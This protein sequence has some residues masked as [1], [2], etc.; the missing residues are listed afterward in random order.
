[1][2]LDPKGA[3]TLTDVIRR[4]AA[5][6]PDAQY[7]ALFDDLVTYERLWTMSGRYAAGLAASGIG[8]C[9]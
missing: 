7:F 2:S 6:T 8:A 5:L 1:M 9:D 3:T 4:R